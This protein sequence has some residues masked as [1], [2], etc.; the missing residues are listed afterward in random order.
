M[1]KRGVHLVGVNH[2]YQIGPHGTIPVEA[3]LEDF[4]EFGSF[5]RGVI[6]R[7]AIRGIA[8]EMSLFALK[9]HFVSGH[10][11]P[12]RVATELEL[13]HRYCD[14]DADA[15]KAL[16]ITSA[17]QRERYW[18]KELITFNAFPVLFILGA[19]HI[20]GFQ[21]LLLESALKP[22]VAARDWQPSS[23]RNAN[24]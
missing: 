3:T 16:N 20:D 13:P 24:I 4:A 6:A 10:S 12:H 14:P 1:T 8:E 2:Q 19:D 15:Q 9:K 7:Y 22:F 17:E 23:L 18:I 11:F 21:Q 5:L